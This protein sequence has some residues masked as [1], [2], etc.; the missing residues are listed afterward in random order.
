MTTPQRADEAARAI[1]AIDEAYARATPGEWRPQGECAYGVDIYTGDTWLGNTMNSHEG[2]YGFPPDAHARTNADFIALAHNHWPAVRAHIAALTAENARLKANAANDADVID[3]LGQ[4]SGEESL[5]LAENARLTAALADAKAEGERMRGIVQACVDAAH[6]R[7]HGF[8]EG[9]ISN[10]NFS[11][12]LAAIMA[13]A[14]A[15]SAPSPSPADPAQTAPSSPTYGASSASSPPFATP[16]RAGFTYP[17]KAVERLLDMVHEDVW[18]EHEGPEPCL[19]SMCAAY[20]ALRAARVAP[21]PSCPAEIEAY[22]PNNKIGGDANEPATVPVPLA[23]AMKVV[24]RDHPIRQHL[25]RDD[26]H[27]RLYD[28]LAAGVKEADRAAKGEGKE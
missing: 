22:S 5:L 16:A 9:D 1:A 6:L 17:D 23:L 15:L 13:A 19:C 27:A 11:K 14:A 24:D 2:K 21:Q 3:V 20:S 25:E 26:L 18:S 8:P 10:M 4:S 12:M 7:T 28:T